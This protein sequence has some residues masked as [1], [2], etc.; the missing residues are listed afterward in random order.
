MLIILAIAMMVYLS[1]LEGKI[2]S[3]SAEELARMTVNEATERLGLNDMNKLKTE[4][5]LAL[6]DEAPA[7]VDFAADKLIARMPQV[8]D[9]I[10]KNLEK[11]MLLGLD[12]IES[13]VMSQ[14]IGL[15]DEAITQAMAGLEEAKKGPALVDVVA[16]RLND[17]YFSETDYLL[18]KVDDRLVYVAQSFKEFVGSHPASLTP[19]ELDKRELLLRFIAV[20]EKSGQSGPEKLLGVLGNSLTKMLD[21]ESLKNLPAITPEE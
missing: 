15:K 12:K 21:L 14:L 17:I 4:F 8:S 1:Y 13:Q 3:Y 6:K 11:Y 5:V 9:T 10:E 2:K 18:Q 7:A 20:M 16:K 19:D